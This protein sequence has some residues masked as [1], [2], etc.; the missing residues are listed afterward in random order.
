VVTS[1]RAANLQIGQ[2]EQADRL[3]VRVLGEQAQA[4]EALT[5]LSARADEHERAARSPRTRAL[6]AADWAHFTGWCDMAR[7]PALPTD[8]ET[9]RWYLTDL[10]AARDEHGAQ[11]Y[12]P[13][14]LAR[15]LAAIAATHRDAGHLSPTR[16]PRVRA[17][18][19]GI[20]RTRRHS[21]HRMTPLLLADLRAILTKI[22]YSHWPGGV[23]GARDAF[24]LLAGFAGALRRSELAALT[25]AD[26]HWHPTDG[27]HV[28][29]RSSKTDQE[30]H[31][32]TVVLPFGEHAGTCPPCAWLRWT[33]LLV[34]SQ[35]GRQSLMR[36]VF[37]TPP[38]AEWTHLCRTNPPDAPEPNPRTELAQ[39]D[40]TTP[41]VCVVAK[42]GA[43]R[44]TAISGD[45]LHAMVKRRAHAA[46]ITAP[47]GFHSLR[48]GFVTQAR[49]AGADTRA[50]RRQTRHS[51]DA[52]VELYDRDHAPLLG[53]AVTE[54]GL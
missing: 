27:V 54:L 10:E 15:R 28:R 11:L 41:A 22:D 25:A 47:V 26:L 43:L 48:A 3:D 38:W 5:V 4:L 30:G 44:G 20:T 37:A 18:L 24:A 39:L 45:G 16:D 34:A 13:A 31:G 50:V 9:L 2:P 6:Y 14:T 1:S 32:A 17:V 46:G 51:S 36:A 8:T 35:G 40:P 21:P 12:Q 52:M 53:N 42:G 19:S 7:R 33:R 23:S 49:R 29:I